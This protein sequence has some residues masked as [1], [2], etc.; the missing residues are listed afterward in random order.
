[1]KKELERQ[2]GKI[3]IKI[4]EK[5]EK[6]LKSPQRPKEQVIYP[7]EQFRGYLRRK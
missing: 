7:P 3:V 2:A 1:M 5:D 4:A 6:R